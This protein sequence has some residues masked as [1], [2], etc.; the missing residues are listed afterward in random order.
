[1]QI[2]ISGTVNDSIVDGPGFRFSIFTQGC[3]H[4][5]AGCQNPQ[6]HSMDGGKLID[7]QEL[8]E[9]IEANP[10]LKGVTL[11]GGEPLVQPLPLIEIAKWC[12]EHNLDVW[13]YSGY[14]FDEIMSGAAGNEAVLLLKNCDVLVDG[15]YI[16]EQ[17]SM[18]IKWRGS[19]NQRV[20]DVKQTLSKGSIV[21]FSE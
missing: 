17:K 4:L 12:H 7:T 19:S 2:R 14:T 3:P 13:A 9:A 11:T 1:M 8:I 20:I 21:E 10:L 6:T 5:C 16:E 18:L 15:P